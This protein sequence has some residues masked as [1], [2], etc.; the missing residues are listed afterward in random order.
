MLGPHVDDHRLVVAAFDIDVGRVDVA[1]LGQAQDGA[2]L[3]AQLARGGGR[4]G[5]YLLCALGG[6]GQEVA[7]FLGF[8]VRAF[9][10]LEAEIGVLRRADLGVLRVLV[11]GHRGP[12]ASLNCTGTRPTP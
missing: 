4:P 10:R 9:S 2:N 6:L 1:A 8:A 3:A 7:V 5:P 12:G 11:V